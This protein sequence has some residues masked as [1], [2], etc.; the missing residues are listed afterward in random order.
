MAEAPKTAHSP[1]LNRT[2]SVLSQPSLSPAHIHLAANI[3]MSSA[4][5][6]AAAL[7]IPSSNPMYSALLV[8]PSGLRAVYRAALGLHADDRLCPRNG[9]CH[10]DGRRAGRGSVGHSPGPGLRPGG[11]PS[12]AVG[13]RA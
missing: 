4:R 5:A 2:A 10:R 6:C 1:P 9:H 13:A 3:Q 11:P 8:S 12:D 7:A